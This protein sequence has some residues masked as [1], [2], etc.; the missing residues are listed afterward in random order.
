VLS[1]RR[2]DVLATVVIAKG[3]KWTFFVVA[4]TAAPPRH[5]YSH[6]HIII[7]DSLKV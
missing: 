1:L 4:T 6:G 3:K 5:H 2:P 7:F